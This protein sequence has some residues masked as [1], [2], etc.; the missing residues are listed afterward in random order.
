V[1]CFDCEGNSVA[2]VYRYERDNVVIG[3][4]RTVVTRIEGVPV[5]VCP[6]CGSVRSGAQAARAR[7]R[8]LILAAAQQ[9][10]KCV[11][12]ELAHNLCEITGLSARS[13]LS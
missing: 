8:G 7:L 6:D 5:E 13:L 2:T 9:H 11:A 3:Q 1:R 12:D 4:G 10:G